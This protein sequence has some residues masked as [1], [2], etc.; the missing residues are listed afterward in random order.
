MMVDLGEGRSIAVARYTLIHGWEDREYCLR[1]WVLEGS[2][3]G[4]TFS[5]IDT[6][7]N[8][9]TINTGYQSATFSASGAQPFRFIRLRQTGA[10][11]RYGWTIVELRVIG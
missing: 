3:D 8:N 9:T 11:P 6:R 5:A 10:D 7:S 1:N 4:K 2:S